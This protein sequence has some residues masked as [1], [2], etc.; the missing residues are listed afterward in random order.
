MPPQHTHLAEKEHNDLLII[1]SI[2]TGIKFTPLEECKK[3]NSIALFKPVSLG[4]T[5]T[6]TFPHLVS[7]LTAS[8]FLATFQSMVQ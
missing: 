2:P 6:T 5:N 1:F 3:K 8:F 4:P 7:F